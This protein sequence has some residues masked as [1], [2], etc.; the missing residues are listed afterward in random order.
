MR[1]QTGRVPH[2]VKSKYETAK[3]ACSADSMGGVAGFD[4]LGRNRQ[5]HEC[6]VDCGAVPAWAMHAVGTR[7]AQYNR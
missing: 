2:G 7:R 1:S 4:R 3:A 5:A 6:I